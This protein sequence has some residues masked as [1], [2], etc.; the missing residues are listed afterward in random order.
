MDAVLAKL[1]V[2]KHRLG[3]HSQSRDTAGLLR[4]TVLFLRG[5]RAEVTNHSQNTC[6]C[7]GAYVNASQSRPRELLRGGCKQLANF[8]MQRSLYVRKPTLWY[9]LR[10][11]ECAF[12]CASI[13]TIDGVTGCI[14]FS[15]HCSVERLFQD[16]MR[17]IPQ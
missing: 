9:N 16:K 13:G 2:Y 11:L 5:S 17:F 1:P 3:E 14:A 15:M 8:L 7:C 12:N 10:K 6:V 4:K